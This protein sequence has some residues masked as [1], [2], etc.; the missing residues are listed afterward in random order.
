[1]QRYRDSQSYIYRKNLST[2][3]CLSALA[4]G[5]GDEQ[6]VKGNCIFLDLALWVN[7]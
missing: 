7:Q 5:F 3:A 4:L 2:S 1:M 6:D